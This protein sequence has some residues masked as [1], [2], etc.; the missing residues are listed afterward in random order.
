MND[1]TR[2]DSIERRNPIQLID[3]IWC[4]TPCYVP[5]VTGRTHER[6]GGFQSASREM[7]EAS[8]KGLENAHNYDLTSSHLNVARHYFQIAG[9]DTAWI[10]ELLSYGDEYKKVLAKRLWW[11]EEGTAKLILIILL[12]GGNLPK[13]IGGKKKSGQYRNSIVEAL[14][15]DK[16]IGDNELALRNAIKRVT[17]VCQ[18]L[19]DGLEAW[20]NWIEY[21]FIPNNTVKPKGGNV[22]IKNAGDSRLHLDDLP[23]PT[24]KGKNRK[25]RAILSTFFLQGMESHFVHILTALG[26]KYGYKVIANEHDG[27]IC[28]GEIPQEAIEVAKR[29][30]GFKYAE[31]VEKPICGKAA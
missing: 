17:K 10:D 3:E 11:K 14:R 31:L 9:I 21:D 7:K 30:S 8:L 13:R 18:P 20:R 5:E 4:Y 6:G 15:R 25:R 28:I 26:V 1:V 12:N 23:V 27:V 29:K 2:Y 22:Y 16:N 19:V 24:K